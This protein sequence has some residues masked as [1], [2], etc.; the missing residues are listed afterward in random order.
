MNAIAFD[1]TRAQCASL[2]FD[3][4]ESCLSKGDLIAQFDEAGNIMVEGEG[5]TIAENQAAAHNAGQEYD[6][7]V[8]EGGRIRTYTGG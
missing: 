4:M 7:Y 8:D 6:F 2:A 5:L 3:E 1:L